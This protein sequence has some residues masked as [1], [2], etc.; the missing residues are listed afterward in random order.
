MFG[1]NGLVSFG[2]GF[3]L[4][5]TQHLGI[6]KDKLVVQSITSSSVLLW[7]LKVGSGPG[8]PNKHSILGFPGEAGAAPPVQCRDGSLFCGM[9]WYCLVDT[10]QLLQEFWAG[11]INPGHSC[12]EHVLCVGD[13]LWLGSKLCLSSAPSL[14]PVL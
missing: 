11:N 3:K 4:T 14:E 7:S 5:S 9:T 13:M 12:I 6:R 10:E 8:V 2:D 1:G